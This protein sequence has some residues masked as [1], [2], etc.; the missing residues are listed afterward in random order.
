MYDQQLT[1]AYYPT[2]SKETYGINGLENKYSKTLVC[3]WIL[4]NFANIREKPL[5]LEVKWNVKAAECYT[6]QG[7]ASTGG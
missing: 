3:K 5:P 1:E 4:Y 7:M 6:N 2:V